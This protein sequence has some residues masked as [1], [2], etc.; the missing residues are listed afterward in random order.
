M[1]LP[2]LTPKKLKNANFKDLT[3]KPPDWRRL[4]TA[5][6]SF[7]QLAPWEW[8][9]DDRIFGVK[10]PETGRIDYCGVLGALGE[11]FAL[12][13]YE[14]AEGLN[15]YLKLLSGELQ[16][17]SH[18]LEHQR[19]L[20]AS[21]DD[22]SDLAPEDLEVIRSLGLKFRGK[23]RWPMFRHYLPGYLPW[24]VTAPQART[25]ATCLEQALDVLPRY[26]QNT[27]LLGDPESG[28]LLVRV[29]GTQKGQD[30]WHDEILPAPGE[31]PSPAESAELNVPIDEIGI[32][33]IRRQA[34]KCRGTWEIG[35]C[36]APM[37][38][39]EKREERPYLPRLLGIVDQESGMILSFRLE[40]SG[41]HLP[42]FRDIILASLGERKFLP[43][44]LLVDHDDVE[45]LVAPMAAGLGIT[46]HRVRELP[47]FAEAL[48]ALLATMG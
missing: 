34:K 33:R 2:D 40:K 10:C 18:V 35:Y 44:H 22:R 41:E 7:R 16:E 43:A 31:D 9:D 36:Y 1:R 46:L 19:C 42:I 21:F 12:I 5:A 23:N 20:M 25:L 28:S 27:A 4:Y 24:F 26:R 13:A 11:V 3:P 6:E 29:Y 32:A 17:R 47:A 38:I 37:P 15:G 45:A 39:R 8:M 14:G 30:G 48:D